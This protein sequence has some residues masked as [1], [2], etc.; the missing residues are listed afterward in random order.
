M[1][2]LPV[3]VR[4]ENEASS[5]QELDA[6]Y[7]QARDNVDGG[8]YH[9]VYQCQASLQPRCVVYVCRDDGEHEAQYN[10]HQPM[11]HIL[12]RHKTASA[13]R[14]VRK[15]LSTLSMSTAMSAH[16]IQNF[17]HVFRVRK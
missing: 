13:T 6:H 8:R 3:K 17:V 12:T 7:F 9:E 5:E 15:R 14:I 2:S 1:H 10:A 11:S 16:C 4:V